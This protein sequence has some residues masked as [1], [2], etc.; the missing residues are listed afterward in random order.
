MKRLLIPILI[1]LDWLHA[2]IWFVIQYVM[3][4]IFYV[5]PSIFWHGDLRATEVYGIFYDLDE[6]RVE[7]I[8]DNVD[9]GEAFPI[10]V[11][12][13]YIISIIVGMTLFVLYLTGTT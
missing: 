8:L 9:G 5:L 11:I 10:V 3:T 4:T 2:T 1:G 6:L 13:F 12:V 7:D